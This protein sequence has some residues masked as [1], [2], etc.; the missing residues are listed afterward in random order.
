MTLATVAIMSVTLIHPR[1]KGGSSTITVWN[2]FHSWRGKAV[3]LGLGTLLTVACHPSIKSTL[4]GPP[5]TAQMAELWTEP[6]KRDLYWGVGGKE[7]APDPA[8]TYTVIEIKR[9]GFSKGYTVKG[10][11]ERQWSAKFPPEAPTEVVS[12]RI[13]WAVGYHQPPVYYLG[14]WMA[15]KATSPNPQLPARFREK[16]PA[17]KG[18]IR[19]EDKGSWSYYRNP[20][21]G[22]RQLKGLLVL[23][24]ML[25]NSDLKDENNALYELREPI[26]GARVW[27]VPRDLG[28]TFGRTGVIRRAARRCRGVREDAVHQGHG[29]RTGQA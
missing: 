11:G 7:L 22:T 6:G 24:A 19:I 1:N 29:E 9:G 4:P 13:L 5:S 26:E 2:G 28:H 3:A 23:Q 10:P 20:F 25:G 27:Y 16:D 15:H 8:A 21:V 17:I 18:R 12:S 14:Q